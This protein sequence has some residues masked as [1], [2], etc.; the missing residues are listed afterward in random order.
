[1][2]KNHGVTTYGNSQQVYQLTWEQNGKLVHYG[3]AADVKSNYTKAL[4]C[5]DR[6]LKDNRPII[7][8]VNH[9]PDKNRNEGATDHFML[10]TGKGYDSVKG[11]YYYTY[12]DPGRTDAAN[13]CNTENNRLYYD[14]NSN[15]F[16]DK[17]GDK[18]NKRFDVTQVRPNDGKQLS[19]TIAQPQIS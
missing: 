17:E 9:S 16:Y 5:I 10:V 13:G 8:G 11:Q 3:N 15:E 12:T 6:H 7:I 2:L 18:D 4:A 14:P 19:E 1:M